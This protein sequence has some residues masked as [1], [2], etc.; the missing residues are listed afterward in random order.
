MTTALNICRKEHRREDIARSTAPEVSF[1][2]STET[3]ELREAL[4]QLPVRQRHACV[5]FYV[6]DLTI[7]SIASAMGV[8]EGAV[9]AHLSQGR[10]RLRQLLE[11]EHE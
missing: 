7:H 11:V 8:T 2:F 4:G 5:L 3:L 6:G 10:K 9:K 1:S